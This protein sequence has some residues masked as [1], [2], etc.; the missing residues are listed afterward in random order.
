M[1]QQQSVLTLGRKVQIRSSLELIG[2]SFGQGNQSALLTQFAGNAHWVERSPL[3]DHRARTTPLKCKNE[4]LVLA[5][6]LEGKETALSSARSAGSK[7]RG[8]G[9]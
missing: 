6:V 8:V 7:S 1:A 9:R 3:L 5:L 2:L 4:Y